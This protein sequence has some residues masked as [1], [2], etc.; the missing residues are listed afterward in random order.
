M[1]SPAKSIG[2]S[3]RSIGACIAL[4][5]AASITGPA[6]ASAPMPGAIN[7]FFVKRSLNANEVHY[8]AV[9]DAER[10]VWVAP[11]VHYYWRNLEEG[12]NDFSRILPFLE[13]RAYGFEVKRL[14]DRAIEI[15]LRALESARIDRPITA[16]LAPADGGCGVTTSMAIAGSEAVFQAAFIKVA[17]GWL[18]GFDYF[19]IL[20]YGKGKKDSGCERDRVYERFAEDDDEVFADKPL[21]DHWR[22][23][24]F[25]Q[26]LDGKC[27]D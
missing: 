18:P 20:G 27:V 8:D 4:G 5:C 25:A 12:P 17:D 13:P 22:S 19:D 1:I 16:R 24:A 21:P 2:S 9:L 23:G 26:G 14:G 7:L 15:R 3:L 6:I 11:Y 10:C